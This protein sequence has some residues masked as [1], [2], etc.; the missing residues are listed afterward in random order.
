MV[1]AAR[2]ETKDINRRYELF[3]E[4]EQHLIDHALVIPLY[5]SGGGYRATYLIHS[6]ETVPSL[7]A[8][9]I[10]L[11]EKSFLNKPMTQE[12][13]KAAEEKYMEE[14]EAA[15]KAAAQAE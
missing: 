13:Y 6:P 8:A 3:A 14:R 2:A 1:N 15:L 5:A 7:D 10:S 9:W 11:K 4:A 12:E